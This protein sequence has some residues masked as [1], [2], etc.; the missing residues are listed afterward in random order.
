MDADRLI[1]A[2]GIEERAEYYSKWG[3][4][5]RAMNGTSVDADHS[6]QT[7]FVLRALLANSQSLTRELEEAKRRS[8]EWF[9]VAQSREP[10]T[11]E[12]VEWAERTAT[13]LGLSSVASGEDA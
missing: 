2:D 10:V 4:D 1:S 8:L 12:D 5:I 9:K 13:E 3:A 6:E 11:A 7:A